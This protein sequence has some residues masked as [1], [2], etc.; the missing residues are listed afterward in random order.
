M[1]YLA[2]MAC[3]NPTQVI[4]YYMYDSIAYFNMFAMTNKINK[5]KQWDVVFVFVGVDPTVNIAVV[6]LTL[7]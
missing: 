6:V 3:T 1:L 2:L 7:R 5:V 4:V